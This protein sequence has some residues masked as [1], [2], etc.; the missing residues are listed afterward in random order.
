VF[1]WLNRII[2]P[3]W[4]DPLKLLEESPPPRPSPRD[5]R[6][7]PT[8]LGAV[9]PQTCFDLL[10]AGYFIT[11][12]ASFALHSGSATSTKPDV[13]DIHSGR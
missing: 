8:T 11:Y 10:L 6:T 12:V 5:Y 3:V 9:A 2:D 1:S 13:A 4:D 7:H